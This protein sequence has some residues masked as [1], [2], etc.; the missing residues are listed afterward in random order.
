MSGSHHLYASPFA[1]GHPLAQITQYYNPEAML[2]PG[3]AALRQAALQADSPR[4]MHFSPTPAKKAPPLMTQ[5]PRHLDRL[6]NEQKAFAPLV[7]DSSGLSKSP[8]VA[9]KVVSDETTPLP[10]FSSPGKG[11]VK[12]NTTFASNSPSD[13]ILAARVRPMLEIQ[14]SLLFEVTTETWIVT[15]ASNPNPPL[16][17]AGVS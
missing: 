5:S 14:D 2:R 17:S 15:M 9:R 6:S 12:M 16:E 4:G 8:Q 1:N 13:M 3:T 10:T 7:T 11:P